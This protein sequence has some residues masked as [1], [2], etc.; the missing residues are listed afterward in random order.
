MS[1]AAPPAT[2]LHLPED[3]ADGPVAVPLQP[4]PAA[5]P[6]RVLAGRHD[7]VHPPTGVEAVASRIAGAIELQPQG[8]RDA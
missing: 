6:F 1:F 5:A 2:T 3:G 7:L 4:S 8:N